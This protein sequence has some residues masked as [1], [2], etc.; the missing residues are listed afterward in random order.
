MLNSTTP[1]L[2]ATFTLLAACGGTPTDDVHSEKP[3]AYASVEIA[4]LDIGGLKTHL[5]LLKAEIETAGDTAAFGQM[6]Y[7]E[8]ALTETLNALISLLPSDST[9]E[10]SALIEK[11]KPLAIKLHLAGHDRNASIGQK[12]SVALSKQIDELLALL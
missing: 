11:I 10:A 4:S 3:G 8:V 5:A 6:H 9:S 12:V 7:L 2:L 1:L